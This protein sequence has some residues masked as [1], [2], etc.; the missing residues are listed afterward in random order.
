MGAIALKVKP[1]RPESVKGLANP[2]EFALALIEDE[3]NVQG[4]VINVSHAAG[5]RRLPSGRQRKL[6]LTCRHTVGDKRSLQRPQTGWPV[7]PEA[8]EECDTEP[9]WSGVR[10][11]K[12]VCSGVAFAVQHQDLITGRGE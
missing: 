5:G 4:A 8:G 2:L 3:R 1:K 9:L 12:D 7:E 6:A 10:G 11:L